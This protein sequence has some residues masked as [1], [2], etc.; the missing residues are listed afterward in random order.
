MSNIDGEQMI[1]FVLPIQFKDLLT[2]TI[3]KYCVKKVLD[4]STLPENQVI[5]TID[6]ITERI[7]N[8][9][10]NIVEHSNFDPLYSLLLECSSI[11]P[12]QRNQILKVLQIG[13]S[14][15][16][17]QV[18]KENKKEIWEQESQREKILACIYNLLELNLGFLWKQEFPEEEFVNLFSRICYEMIEYSPSNMR[19]KSI[20]KAIFSII[21]ILIQKYNHDQNFTSSIIRLLNGHETLIAH[22]AD[23]YESIANDYKCYY[24]ISN[25]IREIGKQKDQRDTSGF[26]NLAKFIPELT[27]RVPKLVLPQVSLLLVHLDAESY[28]LRNAVTESM[29]YLICKAFIDEKDKSSSSETLGKDSGRDT[30]INTLFDRVYDVNGYSRSSVLKT[31]CFIVQSEKLPMKFFLKLTQLAI[32][33][34][35][36]KTSQTRKNAIKLLTILL[37]NNIYSPNLKLLPLFEKKKLLD[38]IIKENQESKASQ[39]IDD[40]DD[41]DVEKEETTGTGTTESNEKSIFQKFKISKERLQEL[42]KDTHWPNVN[43]IPQFKIPSTV[44]RFNSWLIETIRFINT[45]NGSIDTLCQ[46]MGSV[47]ITDIQESIQ[48]F[49]KCFA[50]QLDCAHTGISKMLMLIWNKEPGIKELVIDAFKTIFL[51]VQYSSHPSHHIAK[52]LIGLTK[53]A[54]LGEITSLEEVI[55]EL[56]KKDLVPPAVHNALWD[57]FSGKVRNM[58]QEDSKGALMILAMVSNND[59][60]IVQDKIGLLV[61]VGL[62]SSDMNEETCLILQKLRTKKTKASTNLK[63][64]P[65]FKNNMIIFE[66]LM[67][68][69]MTVPTLLF[70]MQ[71]ID[72]IYNLAE[73]PDE[74]AEQ[75]IKKMSSQLLVRDDCDSQ[76]LGRFIFIL[77]HIA[78]KQLVHIEEIRS[79]LKRKK[80]AEESEKSEK[81]SSESGGRKSKSK[82]STVQSDKESDKEAIEKELGSEVAEAEIEE[83]NRQIAAEQDILSGDNI[84]GRFKDLVVDICLNRGNQFNDQLLQSSAVLTLCKFMC[85]NSEFCEKNLQLLFTLLEASTNELIRSNIVIC[86]GDLVF[87]FTNLL[88]PWTPRIYQRLRDPNVQVRKYLLKVLTHLILNDMIKVKGQIS[89]M[90]IC[91]EDPD[92]DVSNYAKLFFTTLNSKGTHLYNVIPDIISALTS[93][94]SG[95]DTN[96]IRNILKF[97]FNFIQK[98]KQNEN[99]VEK[100]IQRLKLSKTLLES[101]NIS[102]CFTRKMSNFSKTGDLK[103]LLDELEK[104]FI[105]THMAKE[106]DGETTNSSNIPKPM[107]K[108]SKKVAAQRKKPQPK[109]KAKKVE[110]SEEEEEEEEES[111]ESSEEMDI[112]SEEEVKN[113]KQTVKSKPTAKPAPKRAPQKKQPASTKK[114]TITTRSRLKKKVE[115]SEEEESSYESSEEKSQSSPSSESEMETDD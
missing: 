9:G 93:N 56:M 28:L 109:G 98:E 61:S 47:N 25:I 14:N 64:Q 78:L 45:I 58:T 26:K 87:R 76:L 100:L 89:E 82:K 105:S 111:E 86:L 22:I 32:D 1:E 69:I 31:L 110:S 5:A 81:K 23:L 13:L 114:T 42:F 44:E 49:V 71:S 2:P 4:P 53:D 107:A 90:A 73:K 30:L 80:S 96:S 33:R 91:L 95:R 10:I 108:S 19:T 72:T 15:L 62:E 70:S 65:R 7:K 54:S 115:S 36:D 106:E 35:S 75:I 79:E 104:K 99:L 3:D 101:Q 88:E 34:I 41:D 103:P 37:E 60:S 17:I 43:E 68:Q 18:Q 12:D 97:L 67:D 63:E 84:I 46:L 38:S 55:N 24:P 52:N 21:A 20:K 74:L 29:G 39:E 27:N 57:I 66:K 59:P 48:F 40:E 51:D 50:F 92:P 77:G 112:D 85:V 94:Q 8:N 16:L 102:Y 83:E 11:T 6:G 113:K